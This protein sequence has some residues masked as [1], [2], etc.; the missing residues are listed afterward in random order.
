MLGAPTM[1]IKPTP[2]HH[3][4][5]TKEKKKRTTKERNTKMDVMSLFSYRIILYQNQSTMLNTESTVCLNS[6]AWPLKLNSKKCHSILYLEE[7]IPDAGLPKAQRMLVMTYLW[8]W[9]QA[10]DF[11]YRFIISRSCGLLQPSRDFWL[12]SHKSIQ[13]SKLFYKTNI[14]N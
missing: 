12:T 4:Q 7:L 2:P 6:Q 9:E 1:Y 10:T 3:R 8:S 5:Q 11:T 13:R 14:E